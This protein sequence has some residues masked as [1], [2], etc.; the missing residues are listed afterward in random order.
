MNGSCKGLYKFK[1]NTIGVVNEKGETI[2]AMNFTLEG[3]KLTFNNTVKGKDGSDVILISV[4]RKVDKLP[5]P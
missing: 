3:N 1:N 2:N 5:I 4:Y